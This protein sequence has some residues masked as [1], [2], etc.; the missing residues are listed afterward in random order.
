MYFAMN[1]V[2]GKYKP[3]EILSFKYVVLLMPT[4]IEMNLNF[5]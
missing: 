4:Y 2:I 5:A 1:D 3:L